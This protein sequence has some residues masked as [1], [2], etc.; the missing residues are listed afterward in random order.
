MKPVRRLLIIISLL[1]TGGG[2]NDAGHEPHAARASTGQ[3]EVW[4]HEPA[5]VP[6]ELCFSNRQECERV[7]DHDVSTR[8]AAEPSPTR[9]RS[10]IDPWCFLNAQ[11]GVKSCHSSE[12]ACVAER[13][14]TL[15]LNRW[16][17][18]LDE[19]NPWHNEFGAPGYCEPQRPRR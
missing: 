10:A 9:C 7:R 13:D 16:A 6:G 17:S 19:E 8:H 15:K 1:L 14:E 3:S 11:G 5:R 12:E 18:Q 2:C 4:C